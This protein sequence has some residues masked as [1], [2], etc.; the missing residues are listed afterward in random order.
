VLPEVPNRILVPDVFDHPQTYTFPKESV[1]TEFPRSV[2]PPSIHRNHWGVPEES[3]FPIKAASFV[4]LGFANDVPENRML[5]PVVF[6]CPLTYTLPKESVVTEYPRSL[7]VPSIHRNH[8]GIPEESS[9]PIKAASLVVLGFV[10]VLPELPNRMLVPV[11]F[12]CPLT[13]TFPKES[14]ATEYP[15]SSPVP[16]IHCNHSGAC[17][18]VFSPYYNYS[19]IIIAVQ[20]A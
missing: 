2:P 20:R 16:S 3:S 14:V 9:F 5:V 18:I 4:V 12:D 17:D 1:V 8:W 19:I 11:V 6:D 13:Y 15:S 10:N 7:S